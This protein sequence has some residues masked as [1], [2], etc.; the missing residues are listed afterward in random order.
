[1]SAPPQAAA[2]ASSALSRPAVAPWVYPLWG[3]AAFLSA[4]CGIGGGLFAVPVLHYLAGLE[5]RRAVATSLCL[6]F[7][8]S[9]VATGVEWSHAES[10]LVP[11]VVVSLVAGGVLG[12]RVGFR[13]AQ[14]LRPAWLK[15]VFA[16][17][18]ALA[19]VRV[20]ALD[21]FS[22]SAAS[23]DAGLDLGS[24]AGV[25]AIGLGGG[26]VAPLLGVGGGLIVIPALFLGVPGVDYLEA[27][28]CSMAMTI[29]VSSQSAWLY[30]RA[31]SV[32]LRLALRLAA[33]T[34]L[35]AVGGV[36]AVHA[37]GWA[38]LARS[39]MGVILALVALRFALDVL[40]ARRAQ[41]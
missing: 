1:M 27:R 29:V 30:A 7:V 8:L 16:I 33:L 41:A 32:D 18:L 11:W 21:T 31:G 24:A 15:A 17:V 10:A 28:A 19:A 14:R 26:F 35:G 25:F 37:D 23:A 6:V 4:L 40:R 39:I 3:A 2:S 38:D 13:V 22:S 9:L 36:L 20:F 12:A 5:L 34:V